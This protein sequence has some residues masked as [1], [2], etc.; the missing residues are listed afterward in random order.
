V[1]EQKDHLELFH[2][3]EKVE[4]VGQGHYQNEGVQFEEKQVVEEF[5]A[6]QGY[7]GH[8]CYDCSV[9]QW[10][11]HVAGCLEVFRAYTNKLNLIKE[12]YWCFKI[13]T[14][15]DGIQI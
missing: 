13:L 8:D 12:Q 1:A 6:A 10:H 3:H 14:Y 2:F 7:P 5:D 15:M 4:L 9:L 11:G